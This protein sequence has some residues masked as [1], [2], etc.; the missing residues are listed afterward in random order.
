MDL[1]HLDGHDPLVIDRGWQEVADTALKFVQR[2]AGWR[3]GN[4]PSDSPSEQRRVERD[5]R[6]Y[7]LGRSHRKV[8]FR[9]IRDF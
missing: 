7:S 4:A 3:F 1:H 9:V 6:T 5:S 2:F 8:R